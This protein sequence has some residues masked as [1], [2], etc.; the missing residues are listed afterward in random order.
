VRDFRLTRYELAAGPATVDGG[1]P[2]ILL[3]VSGSVELSDVDGTSIVLGRGRSAYLP[4]SQK[5]ITITGRG[6]VYRATTSL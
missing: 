2:Q 3:C 6:T 4:A 1:V 5:A